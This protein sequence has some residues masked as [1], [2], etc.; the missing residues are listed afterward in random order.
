MHKI[1]IRNNKWCQFITDDKSLF[2]KLRSALSFKQ[3]GVE[4]TAA[5]QNGWSGIIFLMDKKGNF[6]AGLQPKVEKILFDEQIS[7]EIEDKRPP[8]IKNDP[9]NIEDKLTQLNLIPRDYQ[10][11]IMNAALNTRKGIIRACTGAGKSICTALITAKINKPTIIYVIGLDLL[12]QFHDLF[13][14]IFDEPI[15]FVG[16]GIC[17]IQRI[18]IASIWTIG[19]ALQINKNITLDDDEECEKN[20]NDS[21]YYKIIDMLNKT[22]LHIFD[23]S[24][25]VATDTIKTIHK[26]IDPEYIYGFSGTPF[27]DDNTD[28]LI[29]GILGEQIIDVSASELISRGILAQP[30]IKFISIPPWRTSSTYPTVYKEY[31]VDSKIRNSIIVDN[32]GKLV[33]K[34]YTPLVLFKQIRHGKTLLKM[35]KDAGIKCE[36][37]YGNDTLERRQEVKQMLLDK[38]I[39]VVLAST[40]FDLGVDL[41]FLNA[42]VLCGSGKSSIR[43]LQRIG[44]VIRGYKGKKI[45]AVID[46]FDQVRFLKKQ[47][48]T[49]YHIYSSENGF[50]VI[51]SKEMKVA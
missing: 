13:S 11:N 38:E 46:F 14:T 15:G 39:S 42:L 21:D 36:M 33:D 7:V 5:Y 49:R 3:T 22:N 19:K 2:N 35:M 1:I 12:K 10:I 31:V 20:I 51:K 9:L 4:Y 34:N 16:N 26:N 30:I 40:I 23:E 48:L 44:R 47:S 29:N 28:L 18:N 32:V 8:I 50:K 45:A 25:V 6:P 24:H 43:A 17:D 41:P 37:L 27:R